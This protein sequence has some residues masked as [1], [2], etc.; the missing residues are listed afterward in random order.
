MIDR[1]ILKKR[2]IE[3]SNHMKADR[4]SPFQAGANWKELLRDGRIF[5]VS[6]GSSFKVDFKNI[7][8][9][10]PEI[11]HQEW[12]AQ[13][14][15]FAWLRICMEEDING[16]NDIFARIAADTINSFYKY[17]EGVTIPNKNFLWEN[18]G[19]NTLSI[20]VRLGRRYGTGWWGTIPFMRESVIDDAFFQKMYESTLEQVYFMI[21]NMT[22]CG[23]WGISQL[24]SLLFLGY[25]FQ[26]K[27]WLKIAVRGLNEAF[28]TQVDDDGVHEEHTLSYH[29]WMTREFSSYFYLSKGLPELGLNIE[30][31]KLIGM[32]EY[33][34]DASCPDGQTVG[35]NDDSRWGYI[36][37]EKSV[38]SYNLAIDIHKDFVTRF[39]NGK[40]SDITMRSKYYKGAGQWFLKYRNE[41]ETQMLVFDATIYGGGHCHR[42]VNSVNFFYGNKMLLLDPG[43][44]N[45]ERSDPFCAYGRQT[46]SHNTLCIDNMTQV[47][48]SVTEAVSDING[49]CVFVNNSYSNG[50]SDDGNSVA[51]T[52]ERFVL[53][54]KGK[55]CIINDSVVSSGKQFSANF[56]FIPNNYSFDGESYA[57]G[58]DDYNLFVKPIYSNVKL[59]IN[60]YEG[61]DKPRAGWIA[62]DGYRLRGAEKGCSLIVSG[63]LAEFGSVVAYAAIPF[64]GN[65]KPDA[66]M[67]NIEELKFD[68]EEDKRSRIFN[69]PV[70]YSIKTSKGTYEVVSAYLKYRDGRLHPSISKTGKYDSDGKL[71]FVEFVDGKPAFAYLYDGTYLNYDGVKLIMETEFG[72]Y[73]K[74]F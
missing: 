43:S 58:F 11:N 41:K 44:F 65:K 6:Y 22:A 55:I 71:A 7:D 10:G 8:F 20:S 16:K 15:R 17:R 39:G 53:W 49:K 19:D 1:N 27:K 45:Y 61:S 12:R 72:N 46:Q 2:I 30:P 74:T 14:N 26:N 57:T 40:Y 9:M 37:A 70:I 52:H 32:W 50:Y 34:I 21:E 47:K 33:I 25:V 60:L 42:A 13:L 31:G 4:F 64:K 63:G 38:L 35:M 59:N 24:S 62:K 67:M 48:S 68:E 5:F 36:N 69:K 56:N 18:L 3:F 51:G 23:N 54:Y 66:A 73:E 29:A 28:Y